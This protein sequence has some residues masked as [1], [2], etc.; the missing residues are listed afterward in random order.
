MKPYVFSRK[1]KEKLKHAYSWEQGG[2]NV[3]F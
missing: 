1:K 2:E 3:N